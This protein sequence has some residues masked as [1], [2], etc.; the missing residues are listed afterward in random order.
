MPVVL[1]C[2]R[3]GA[4][5]RLDIHTKGR[6]APIP[7]RAP[8]MLHQPVNLIFCS[9]SCSRAFAR[10]EGI[11]RSAPRARRAA[12]VR[13]PNSEFRVPVRPLPALRDIRVRRCLSQEALSRRAGVGVFTVQR[14]EAGKTARLA[15]VQKLARALG[16]TPEELAAP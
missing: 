3:C 7:R 10:E 13:I 5:Q 2:D 6:V 16:V 4:E 11:Q 12:R 8:V 9:D 14:L 1:K 15:T